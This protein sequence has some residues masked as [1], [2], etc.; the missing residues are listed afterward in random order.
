MEELRDKVEDTTE[1]ISLLKM[2]KG[3]NAISAAGDSS[4]DNIKSRGAS[5]ASD[6]FEEVDAYD[7]SYRAGPVTTGM[8][9]AD[10]SI[11]NLSISGMFRKDR[12]A[13]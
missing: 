5:V 8:A 13:S 1:R 11:N 7:G 3:A 4:N 10:H 2:F 12:T 9:S 6:E